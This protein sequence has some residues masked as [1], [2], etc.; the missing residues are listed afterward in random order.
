M[1]RV[2][3]LLP[4]FPLVVAVCLCTALLSVLGIGR[5]SAQTG[6]EIICWIDD[7]YWSAADNQV[8]A[9]MPD[10]VYGLYPCMDILVPGG[11]SD[12]DVCTSPLI[13]NQIY[14]SPGVT[15]CPEYGGDALATGCD[16]GTLVGFA[17]QRTSQCAGP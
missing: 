4:S 5:L 3:G 7:C 9:W 13:N 10:A 2:R 16:Y 1:N 12:P 6:C 17:R 14:T 8:Y 11:G 15:M